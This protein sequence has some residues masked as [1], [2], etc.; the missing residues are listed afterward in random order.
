[1]IRDDASIDYVTVS[2]D[3]NWEFSF[4]NLPL[5]DRN[6]NVIAYSVMMEADWQDDDPYY[7]IIYDG[8]NIIAKGKISLRITDVT[9]LSE[10]EYTEFKDNIP[11][12]SDGWWWLRSPGDQNFL[13]EHV[14]DD[15]SVH[16]SYVYYDGACVR[17]A[18][19]CDLDHSN[20]SIGDK[21]SLAGYNWTVINTS[22]NI[23]DDPYN[24]KAIILC[25]YFVGNTPFRTDTFAA[26]ANVYAVSDVKVWLENWATEKGVMPESDFLITDVTLL[27]QDEYVEYKDVISLIT[28]NW[29]L[30]SLGPYSAYAS[31][32]VDNHGEVNTQYWSSS[33]SVGVRP[34]ILCDLSHSN[35]SV[36]DQISLAG[37]SWTVLNNSMILCDGI[38]GRTAFRAEYSAPDSN[39]YDASDVKQW[40][41]NWVATHPFWTKTVMAWVVE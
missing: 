24:G 40:L 33:N 25:D 28:D 36:G 30:R 20:L 22:V 14:I 13:A 17:P 3:D 4:E 32:M 31:V 35:Y 38:V 11:L 8:D 1:M 41:A 6:G 21:I 5:L 18:L 10:E 7:M 39:D 15:G 26:D 23:T 27:S 2:E 29:W 37:Y 16:S 19:I 34:V 12:N 9:L